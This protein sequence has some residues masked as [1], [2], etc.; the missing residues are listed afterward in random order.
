[1]GVGLGEVVWKKRRG[2]RMGLDG[3][4]VAGMGGAER[5]PEGRIYEGVVLGRSR[6]SNCAARQA[7]LRAN[8]LHIFRLRHLVCAVP[9]EP[10]HPT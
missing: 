1:M 4:W 5:G 6:M 8:V 9:H 3:R 7:T 10:F 2:L